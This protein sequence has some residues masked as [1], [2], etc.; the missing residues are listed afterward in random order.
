ML[1]YVLLLATFVDLFIL[2][3]ITIE[4]QLELGIISMVCNYQT[5]FITELSRCIV[6]SFI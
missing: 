2:N 3:R 5:W 1:S 4:L 6:A